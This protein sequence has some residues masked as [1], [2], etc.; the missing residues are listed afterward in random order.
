MRYLDLT[1]PSPAEN[2][3]LDETLLDEAEA[4]A[5][6]LETLRIWD[7]PRP[8]AVVGRS[9]EIAREVRLDECRSDAVPVLRRASGGGAVVA[10]PGCLMYALVLSY[11]LRP[12][13]RLVHEAH[14]QVLGMLAAA[15]RPRVP[16]LGCRGISDLAIGDRKCSGNSMRCKRTHLLYH[17]TFLYRFPLE[18]IERY[19]QLPPRQPDYRQGRSHQAFVTNLPLDAAALRQALLDALPPSEPCIFWPRERTA[20][21]VEQRYGRREWNR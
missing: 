4:A 2:I 13:L 18:W 8:L 21:L 6:P 16:E 20:A 12:P 3:A 14:R 17:G 11:Q 9:S 5:G 19:L 1:L 15:L 10:G 7:S